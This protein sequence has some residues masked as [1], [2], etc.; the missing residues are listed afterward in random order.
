MEVLPEVC[1]GLSPAGSMKVYPKLEIELHLLEL[2][3]DL[4]GSFPSCEE[5]MEGVQKQLVLPC[6]AL[7][8]C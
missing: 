2:R 3:S 6:A 7:N 8:T 4:D 1:R 5:E